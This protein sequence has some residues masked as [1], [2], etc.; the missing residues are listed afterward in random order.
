MA[1]YLL[2]AALTLASALFS[3]HAAGQTA[4][5]ERLRAQTV[6]EV[7]SKIQPVLLQYCKDSCMVID[8]APE[9]DEGLGESEDLGFEG[10]MGED[11]ASLMVVAKVVVQIQVDDRVTAMNRDRLS[12]IIKNNMQSWVT[13]VVWKP[14]TLPQI[15]Q[16]MAKEEQL[17]RM[18]QQRISQA[19]DKVIEA[20]CPETCVL[21]QTTVEGKLITQD[22][23]ADVPEEELARD[24]SGN[25]ILKID[26]IDVEVSVDDSV[27]SSNR[28]KIVN[29]MKAKTRFHAPVNL[30]IMVTAFPESYAARKEKEEQAS[31]DPYGLGR[32]RE[33]LKIFRELAGTKEIITTNTSNSSSSD[34]S[35]LN[36]RE[37]SREQALRQSSEE[38]GGIETWEWVI[39]AAALIVLVGLVILLIVRFANANR[40]ARLMMQEVYAPRAD[41]SGNVVAAPQR[42][43]SEKGMSEEQRRDIGL[44]MRI[45]DLK[46]ELIG[47]FVDQPKVAKETFSRLLQEEGIEETAKYVHIFGHMVVF[48]LLGDPNLQ[49][50]LFELSEYYHKSEF[51]FNSDEEFKLLNALK[52]RVTANEIR[53]LTR[54]QMD[55]FDFLTKLDSTQIYNLISEEKPQVQ[56]IVLTQLDH[57]RRRAV[58]EMY[59][60]QAKVELMRELCRADAIPKDYLSN[61][62]MV[63]HKKVTSRPEFDTENLRSSDIL[64]DLLEKAN[65]DEQKALMKN[66]AETNAD[67]ARAIKLKLVTVEVIPYLKDGHLLEIMLGLERDDVKMFLAGTR[68]HIRSLILSK[69]P[70]ELADSWVEDL[71]NMAGFDEQAFR[72]AEMK[73]LSRVRSLVNNGV[74]NLIDLNDMIF[75]EQERDESP[76]AATEGQLTDQSMVA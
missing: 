53:V 48:E 33:T 66:L 64:L 34:R 10:V 15:G 8:I 13:D 49:R 19:V 25:G 17:K 12:A 54:K 69:A 1:V 43:V 27:S 3:V 59:Q 75:A 30:D 51:E 26:G 7:R 11:A 72:L 52:T 57:K 74:I 62:A 50:D 60:G 31:A 41:Q 63:L 58:F 55:Q 47:V 29:V 40:D 9:I 76:D 22:E 4:A 71:E 24:K 21:S 23:S 6:A 18:V 20:Y 37:Q 70:D 2:P 46:K 36:S 39:Y 42:V 73:I 14:V 32:L 28:N 38:T 16:S 61:V 35:E 68:E 44:R 67:A 5:L 65:L 56:S 45:E